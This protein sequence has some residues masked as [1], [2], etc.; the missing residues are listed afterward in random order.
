MKATV[1]C[2][3]GGSGA[4]MSH[5]TSVLLETNDDLALYSDF[6]V[7]FALHC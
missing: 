5:G 6:T 4:Y 3:L 1:A 7:P 2:S